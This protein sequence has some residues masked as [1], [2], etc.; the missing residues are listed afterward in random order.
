[1]FCDLFSQIRC[2]LLKVKDCSVSIVVVKVF[3]LS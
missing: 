3:A 2:I 1:M